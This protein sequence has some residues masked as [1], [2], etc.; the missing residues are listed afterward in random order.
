MAGNHNMFFAGGGEHDAWLALREEE[1]LDPDLPIVDAHHHLWLREPPPYLLREYVADITTG[2]NVVA[3]VFAECH[4]MYRASGP[5]AFRPVGETEFTTGIA[6]MA[7]SG[8]FG[9]ARICRATTGAVDCSMGGDVRP[10]LE[11]H[12]AAGRGRFRGVRVSA[13]YHGD[14]HTTVDGPDYLG[15]PAVREAIGVLDDMGL[16][17]DVWVYHTQLDQVVDLAKSFPNLTIILNHYGAPILGAEFK[18]REDEVFTDWQA[19]MNAIGKCENVYIKLGAMVLRSS[20]RSDP[21]LPPSSD[22]VVRAW[23]R[24]TDHAIQAFTPARAFFESNFP[25]HKRYVSFAVLYNAFKKMAAGYSQT[26]REDLFAG[27]AMRAY[28]FDL[29]D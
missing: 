8:V 3:S 21:D 25:V 22:D 17:L 11:A 19:S 2:H 1:I 27:S 12:V 26:E 6:A 5:E 7:D 24:W 4:S 20:D 10:V 18:G 15:Y 14:L 23:G 13:P 9:S 16:S 29:Q 28:R